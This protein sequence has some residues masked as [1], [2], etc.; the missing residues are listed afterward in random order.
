ME[1]Q[2]RSARGI[3]VTRVLVGIQAQGGWA[4]A[5][6]LLDTYGHYLPDWS[7]RPGSNRRQPTWEID[8]DPN[9]DA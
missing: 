5:K 1:A 4:S 9:D 8:P 3:G 6:M 7:A 2:R